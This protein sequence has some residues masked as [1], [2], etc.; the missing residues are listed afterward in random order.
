M[1]KHFIHYH[2]VSVSEGIDTETYKPHIDTN[3]NPKVSQR[4]RKC[5]VLLY[6][7]QNFKKHM[8][9][10]DICYNTLDDERESGAIHIVWTENKNL[11]SSL[12]NIIILPQKN[13]QQLLLATSI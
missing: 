7:D 12:T 4:C 5:W 3:I 13:S 2:R 8:S 10:C 6:I 1:S 9:I 11:E